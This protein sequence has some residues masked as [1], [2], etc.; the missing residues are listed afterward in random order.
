MMSAIGVAVFGAGIKW[1]RQWLR[2]F[3]S[4]LMMIVSLMTVALNDVPWV[5]LFFLFV[6]IVTAY[7]YDLFDHLPLLKLSLLTA[8]LFLT[9]LAIYREPV[10]S[11]LT[12]LGFV[13]SSTLVG[14]ILWDKV[15]RLRQV[16]KEASS[17]AHEAIDLVKK[18][19]E[20]GPRRKS[21]G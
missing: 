14:Y 5:G 15:R 2:W 17:I 12:F 7:A 1:D 8:I 16:A 18:E 13:V 6:S 21:G 3:Q 10:K 20:N 11:L 4:A 19:G 9:F